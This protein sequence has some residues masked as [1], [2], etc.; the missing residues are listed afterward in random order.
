[1]LDSKSLGFVTELGAGATGLECLSAGET[2]QVVRSPNTEEKPLTSFSHGGGCGC[3]VDPAELEVLLSKLPPGGHHPN[4][5]VGI[6]TRDDAAVYRINS[7]DGLVF[8]NDF[9][10]P[11]VDDPYVFGRAAAANALSDVYAMG[12]VPLMANAIAGF[13]V[14]SLSDETLQQIVRGGADVC[15]EA[16][17]PLS[18]GHTIDNP[19]PIFGLAVIG[20]IRLR[21]IKKNAGAR[22]GDH[23]VLSK[24]LGVGVLAS[25]Y[26][27]GM[28]GKAGHEELV[29]AI[30]G[31][32][33]PGMWLG[34][35]R[36]VNAMTDVT[37]F[38]LAGHL[39]E[40]AEG[41]GVSIRIRASDV[42]IL[43]SALPLAYEGLFPGGAYRNMEAYTH[44]LS[45]QDD[46]DLDRQLLFSDPQTNGGLL[47]SVAPK[48]SPEI[49]AYLREQG[50][51][52]A[53][54]IGEVLPP[55]D[56]GTRVTFLS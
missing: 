4:L 8:T 43:D 18:G 39:V 35:R 16:G 10:T 21:K 12:G 22:V 13:P 42:P 50:F 15:S 32:N 56:D 47:V 40:M 51:A 37:G 52:D 17:I 1:M 49:L 9:F 3:K 7:R 38:G 31:I 28:L 19:Q 26:R 34:D 25:A 27:L 23:L 14:N 24:P 11:T 41:S 46:W 54:V 6:E 30:T 53:A 20:R 2:R 36:D 29:R 33:T 55:T 5:V 44:V 45:F 48:S